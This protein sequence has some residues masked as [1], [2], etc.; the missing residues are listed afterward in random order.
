MRAAQ[1]RRRCVCIGVYVRCTTRAP[2]THAC[3]PHQ[4]HAPLQHYHDS[5][6]SFLHHTQLP[7]LP[8][9]TAASARRRLPQS[10]NAH[11]APHPKLEPRA[12]LPS[13]R[14]RGRARTHELE[15]LPLHARV[16]PEERERERVGKNRRQRTRE[17]G[18]QAT[19]CVQTAR[20][21]PSNYVRIG[22]LGGVGLGYGRNFV[23]LLLYQ[24]L[25]F[26]TPLLLYHSTTSLVSPSLSL[27][28][29][30]PTLGLAAPC[31]AGKGSGGRKEGSGCRA[32]IQA[33]TRRCLDS[34]NASPRRRAAPW[35][36]GGTRRLPPL[37]PP[38][39][40]RRQR[41]QRRRR[42]QHAGWT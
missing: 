9:T 40:R 1:Y 4:H 37:A 13:G 3:S 30:C 10:T 32:V 42:H 25:I 23:L 28:L 31:T 15:R 24:N 27:P 36:G 18:I 19:I 11:A 5:K 16:Q 12:A 26:V 20:S 17:S 2:N 33:A 22:V 7:R 35:L 21:R 39:R 41:R 29:G 38:E 34:G 6:H 14:G 8:T